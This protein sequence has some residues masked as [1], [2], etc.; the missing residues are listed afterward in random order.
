MVRPLVCCLLLLCVLPGVARGHGG[1][2]F[3]EDQC[4]IN[5]DFLQAHFTVFQPETRGNEEFCEA[6][7]DVA[8]SVFVMEYLHQLLSEMAV[9]FRIVRDVN[10]VGR[11]A[12]WDD[13]R[14]IADLEAATVFY[15]APAI[16]DGGFY[17][18][19]Y[20]FTERGD[21]IGVVTAQ[22]PTED[23]LYN[24]VFFFRVGGFNPGTLPLFIGLLI[25]LQ[26]G[27]WYSTGGFARWREK[28]RNSALF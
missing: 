6:I 15:Q 19:S 16:E 20:E 3:A 22:H 4:V 26:F 18:T 28:R 12:S 17:R 14:A 25:V 8:R 2:A 5:I 1:V 9:D 13:V 21:Y 24:A 10:G 23:R 27:Y 7:P 11:F